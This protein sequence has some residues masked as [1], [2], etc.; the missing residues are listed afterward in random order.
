MCKEAIRSKLCFGKI[1]LARKAKMDVEARKPWRG[2]A[3]VQIGCV[4]QK[5][6]TRIIGNFNSPLVRNMADAQWTQRT[7]ID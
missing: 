5:S 2:I 6:E 3:V 1:N 7:Q 4:K